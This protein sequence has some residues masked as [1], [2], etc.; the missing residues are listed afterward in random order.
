[1]LL[2]PPSV[3]LKRGLYLRTAAPPLAR[4]EPRKDMRTIEPSHENLFGVR[5]ARSSKGLPL[6]RP[7]S[8]K[9]AACILRR[10]CDAGLG[11]D[12]SSS[13]SGRNLVVERF[14]VGSPPRSCPV[15]LL[16]A[17]VARAPW[18]HLLSPRPAR[19]AAAKS[20]AFPLPS[21]LLPCCASCGLAWSPRPPHGEGS[22]FFSGSRHSL[23]LSLT[24]LEGFFFRQGYGV[25]G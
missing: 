20:A 14:D 23:S 19:W 8:V 3:T 13:P 1:M 18:W 9:K 10:L 15:C 6:V 5:G 25:G 24:R 12:A 11:S 4:H 16:P 22:T 17:H 7:T 21:Y 2:G